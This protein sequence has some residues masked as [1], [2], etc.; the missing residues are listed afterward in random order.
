MPTKIEWTDE[1][2]NP[3]VGCS[4]VSEGCANC[5]AERMAVR[6]ASMGELS[7]GRGERWT[8]CPQHPEYYGVVETTGL[9]QNGW[10][11]KTALVESV[12]DKPLHWRKPRRVFVGS[13]TDIFHPSV[14]DEW[15]NL[16]WAVM[17]KSSHYFLLLT[18]RPERMRDY[19][20]KH[21][22]VFSGH[23][24]WLGVTTENQRCA[25]ERIPV[26]LQ[27]PA[28]VRFVSV[29]PM[30]E[31]VDIKNALRGY[32]EQTSAR[33]YVTHEMALDAGQ[34]EREGELYSDDEWQ[35]TCPPLN[36]VIVGCES[37]PRR[38]P[39][40]HEW[41]R[42]LIQQ[43]RDAG[44]PCFVKQVAENED[45]TGKVVHDPLPEWGVREWPDHIGDAT[46]M[47]GGE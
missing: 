32:P 39:C 45:G 41:M 8:F 36:W 29:E 27:T 7:L 47:I 13:M 37:G 46:K 16:V 2:Y 19:I 18:K 17:R 12:L 5:Y 11:G 44:V 6:L 35:Q 20:K 42:N 26:L 25:D 9:G 23:R 3:I 33:Q 43:C 24:I 28:A 4:K 15:L 38:R 10:N 40:P 31:P 14:P 1:T 21:V 22:P 30:L 34:P